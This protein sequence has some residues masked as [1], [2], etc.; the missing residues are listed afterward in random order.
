MSDWKREW[1]EFTGDYV[2]LNGEFVEVDKLVQYIKTLE[3]EYKEVASE[4]VGVTRADKLV[5]EL[6]EKYL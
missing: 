3:E 1:D 4:Q 5:Q 2:T 6:Q